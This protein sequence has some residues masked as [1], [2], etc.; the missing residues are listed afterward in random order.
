MQRKFSLTFYGFN[1]KIKAGKSQGPGQASDY[2]LRASPSS[3]VASGKISVMPLGVCPKLTRR[4]HGW[5]RARKIFKF[6]ASRSS[7]TAFS[8]MYLFMFV[9]TIWSI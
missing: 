9:G 8:D 4:H 7:E 5:R 2:T 6:K 3:G 1:V